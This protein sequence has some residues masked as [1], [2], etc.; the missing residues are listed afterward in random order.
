LVQKR[1]KTKERIL[2]MKAFMKIALSTMA[3]SFVVIAVEA[4]PVRQLQNEQ[5][6][7]QIVQRMAAQSSMA[8]YRAALQDG[9]TQALV[10]SSFTT[11]LS[12]EIAAKGIDRVGTADIQNAMALA[13][14]EILGAN[15]MSNEIRT[16]IGSA[17]SAAYE[18]VQ[19]SLD[20]EAGIRDAAGANAVRMNNAVTLFCDNSAVGAGQQDLAFSFGDV[21]VEPG[22]AQ[23]YSA[24][25]SFSTDF[26]DMV[27][28]SPNR[29]ATSAVQ[30]F[31]NFA[32]E[33]GATG[34]WDVGVIEGARM[35]FESYLSAEGG[36]NLES[37]VNATTVQIPQMLLSMPGTT[38]NPASALDLGRQIC[39]K[40][41]GQSG[42][43]PVAVPGANLADACGIAA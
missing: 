11:Y 16:N 1:K 39:V 15:L 26:A 36:T 19:A 18:G 37:W 12:N 24:L 42:L 6:A 22:E 43:L 13:F 33:S 14:G 40:C 32:V 28:S 3:L 35:V 34:T 4:Q 10:T 23:F 17:F 9:A 20:S 8:A 29:F 21:L 30:G 5:V 27:S 25:D 38:H 2:K 31:R 7:Q 41:A